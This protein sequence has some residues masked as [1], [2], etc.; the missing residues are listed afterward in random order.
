MT[1]VILGM[2]EVG[3]TL[4]DLLVDR[5]FDCVG[6]DLDDSKCKKYSEN[7]VIKNPEYLPLLK[8]KFSIYL[9]LHWIDKIKNIQVVSNIQVKK[10][11]KNNTR[12]INLVLL[13]KV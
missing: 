5:K 13:K 1:D 8:I 9:F 10:D 6:I 11:K 2:G 3:Q 7:E 12:K 4:F